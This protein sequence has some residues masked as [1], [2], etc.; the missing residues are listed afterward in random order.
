MCVS[1]YSEWT[2][3]DEDGGPEEDLRGGFMVAG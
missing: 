2:K 3:D 1:G